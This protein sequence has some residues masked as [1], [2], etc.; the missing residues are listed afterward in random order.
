MTDAR[1]PGRWLMDPA[2]RALGADHWTVF[3]WAL[4]WSAEQG[5]DGRIPRHMLP[6]LHPNGATVADAEAL[7]RV[8]LWEADGDDY[9]VQIGS[10]LSRS[11]RTWST[12]VSATG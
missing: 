4:M 1:L 9:R 12:S 2:I 11:P 6:L 7:V 3:S 10:A 8:G 5:T